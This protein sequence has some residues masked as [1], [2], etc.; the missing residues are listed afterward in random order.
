M[1]TL[2]V[3]NLSIQNI[4][5]NIT[6]NQVSV[7]TSI[8]CNTLTVN[9][10]VVCNTFTANTITM[11]GAVV[12]PFTSAY[13]NKIINGN[14][15][16]WQRGTSNTSAGY[17]TAD[18]WYCNHFGSTRTASRQSFTLGQTAVPGEPTYFMRHVVTSS[19][20]ASNYCVLQQRIESVRTLAGR[21]AT[22][23]FWAKADASK[24]IA[25]EFYQSFGSGGGASS[26]VTS[27]GVT[28]CALTT[29]WQKFTVTASIPS[30]SGKTIGSDGYDDLELTI[31][32][33]AGSTYNSR[34]SSLGQQSGTFDIAQVQ[35]EEG[36]V[37][38]SFEQRHA[39]QEMLL[40][41]RYFQRLGYSG[42][43][44]PI[45]AGYGAAGATYQWSYYIGTPMRIAPTATKEGTWNVTNCS[46]PIVNSSDYNALTL[47]L[48]TTALGNFLA[49]VDGAG[50]GITLDAEI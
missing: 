1:S 14:F 37:A 46:Q 9:T 23:S 30:I 36:P 18:R 38:T 25:I 13:K 44:F 43:A 40:C 26:P 35:V 16:I 19:A 8:G 41:Q 22:L 7:N 27:I 50:K 31:W 6:A 15:D 11:N 33:E 20:G 5:G 21:T 12:S 49:Y 34:T 32:F 28:T 2:S 48:T 45:F 24:N 4:T 39:G 29:S 10:S 17:Y 42:V 47:Q 3:T